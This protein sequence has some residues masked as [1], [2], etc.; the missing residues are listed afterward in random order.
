MTINYIDFNRLL[1]RVSLNTSCPCP[2]SNMADEWKAMFDIIT[3][4]SNTANTL[5]TAKKETQGLLYEV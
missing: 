2:N 4:Y 3:K 5:Y 1:T